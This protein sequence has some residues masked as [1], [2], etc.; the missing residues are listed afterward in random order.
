MRQ[1]DLAALGFYVGQY[2][3][4]AKLQGDSEAADLA[5]SVIAAGR[6]PQPSI[7]AACYLARNGHNVEAGAVW[8]RIRL[9]DKVVKKIATRNSRKHTGINAV[10]AKKDIARA[11]RKKVLAAFHQISNKNLSAKRIAELIQRE[12][13][14]ISV[15]T[16]RRQ[17]AELLAQK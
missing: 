7:G 3:A 8:E 13:P 11:D 12:I 5:L 4:K 2:A 14:D 9:A 17:V 15:R 6:K 16:L 10:W 1:M